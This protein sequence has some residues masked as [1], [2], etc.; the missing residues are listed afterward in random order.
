MTVLLK[1]AKM[2]IDEPCQLF[3]W[4]KITFKNCVNLIEQRPDARLHRGSQQVLLI[5]EILIQ[6]AFCYT[7][8]MSDC[9]HFEAFHAA[10]ADDSNSR[11]HNRLPGDCLP[12]FLSFVSTY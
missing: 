8:L 10:F 2:H 3:S 6:R 12:R 1:I 9:F 11:I 5:F 7:R 4:G